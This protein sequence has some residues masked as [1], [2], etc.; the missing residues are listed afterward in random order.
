LR[1]TGDSDIAQTAN[2]NCG[3]VGSSTEER[4]PMNGLQGKIAVIAG[5]GQGIGAATAR[6]L[7]E[8]RSKV[9]VGDLV[10]ERAQSVADEIAASGGTAVAAQFDLSD[11][12]SVRELIGCAVE[13]YGG[14][15]LLANIGALL[16]RGSA[17]EDGDLM[18]DIVTLKT[19]VW[20]QTMNVNLRGY[21][22]TGRY[23]IPEMIKRGGGA[24]VNMSSL[25]AVMPIPVGLAYSVSKA[26]IEAL[27]RHIVARFTAE[28]IRA[29]AV[30]PGLVL[31][32]SGRVPIE[33]GRLTESQI[34]PMGRAG[35][36]EEVAEVICFL[37]SSDCEYLT[38]QVIAVNGGS[39][40]SPQ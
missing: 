28:G 27:T 15:D 11:D 14:V 29:N 9:V 20:E 7:A 18:S 1:F 17:Y 16:G 38:G 24:I 22:F 21:L 12:E 3:S 34:S 2:R 19:D 40:L 36:P 30:A 8:E 4:D 33:D 23:A 26:G 32:P 39:Y 25:A 10:L 35:T 13:T 31:S 5:G 6:R 37:L